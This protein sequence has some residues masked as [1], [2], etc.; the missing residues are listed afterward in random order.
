MTGN[1]LGIYG[2]FASHV[3]VPSIDLCEVKNRGA[4]PLEH[5][6]VIADAGT[7]P[8][9]AARKSDVGP[10]DNVIVIGAGGVGQYMIQIAKAL[11]TS[12]VIAIDIDDERLQKTLFHGADFVINSKDKSAKDISNQLKAIR[13]HNDLPNYGWKIFEVS[14]T[15]SGQDLAL[16]LLGFI[17][18]LIIIGFGLQKVEYS[19]SRLMAF[20]AEIIG[21]W[22]CLP[23]YYPRV[24]NMVLTKKIEIEPF[25]QTRP[26]SSIA[27]TFEEVHKGGSPIRRIVLT[28]DF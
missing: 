14:G 22:G 4:T 8:Y 13:R 7:T 9:Q 19:I 27:E 2:G 17:G 20:D 24:L 6:A 16:S 26:M 12:V 3:P 5:L 28:P 21:V 15:G 25:V 1:S 11:G 23:E 10:G 18:K